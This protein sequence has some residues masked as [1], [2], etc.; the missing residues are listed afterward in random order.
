[1]SRAGRETPLTVAELVRQGPVPGIRMFGA[2]G[3]DNPVLAVRIIDRLELL[4]TLRPREAVALTGAAAHAG[5]SI[6][7][8]LRKA[9]EHAA[10]CVVAPY[11]PAHAGSA[12][13]LADRL[14]IPLL[15][16][17]GEPLEAAVQI[18]SAVARPGA[19]RTALVAKAALA[20]S[21]P[22]IRNADQVLGVL[23]ELLPGMSVAFVDSAG[24]LTA[25]RA[26][27][28]GRPS[29]AEVPVTGPHGLPL[30][31]LLA[32]GGVDAGA[33]RETVEQ[34]LRLAV[35]V[36]TAWAAT[37][38]LADELSA[39][40]SA[41]LLRRLLDSAGPGDTELAARMAA[42]GWPA[43]GPM[44]AF[45][46]RV[47]GPA[48]H[49]PASDPG[50]ALRS[51]WTRRRVAGPL[52]PY[53]DSWVAWQTVAPDAADVPAE[54]QRAAET[55]VRRALRDLNDVI[56]AVG[57]I[58]GPFPGPGQLARALEDA[59]A[60]AS[61]AAPSGAGTVV[62]ADRMGAAHLLAAVPADTLRHPAEVIL[63]PLLAADRDGAL[64]RTL[65]ALL[66]AGS[67]PSVAAERLDVHRN[68]VTAR[69]ER[70]RSLGFDPDDPGQ[71]LALH[72]ACRVL[73]DT[74]S[75][76]PGPDTLPE[77]GAS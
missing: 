75:A 20:L 39:G 17:G 69:L 25:G 11:A 52:V 61:V 15:L 18:A 12:G 6:D 65:A 27:A 72:L 40:R 4:N 51:A 54:A 23:H 1:M 21:D 76:A 44:M 2:A 33:R 56:P 28:A 64:L 71:R 63:A 74:R 57:G 58:A 8:A 43:R 10:S 60:A 53:R 73:L 48:G 22:A 36:L 14:G 67:A 3:Q 42:A 49:A 66:D 55:L 77:T 46:L 37:E 31:T 5:W 45:A 50:A 30:G 16:I 19:G 70:I 62:R 24:T 47:A 38:R 34:V 32:S 35:P 41:A 13:A 7:V 59:C 26:R 68:T 9:W 29:E